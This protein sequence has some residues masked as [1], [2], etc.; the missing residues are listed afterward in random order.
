MKKLRLMLL[1]K[2]RVSTL[3]VLGFSTHLF[4]QSFTLLTDERWLVAQLPGHPIGY[5]TPPTSYADFHGYLNSFNSANDYYLASVD[6]TLSAEQLSFNSSLNLQGA[7]PPNG[8]A[9]SFGAYCAVNF[10]VSSPV[11]ATFAFNNFSVSEQGFTYDGL[12]PTIGITSDD[13]GFNPTAAA[14]DSPYNYTIDAFDNT[15]N[16][17][18]ELAFSPNHTYT[19]FEQMTGFGMRGGDTTYL[20]ATLQANMS[21]TTM[22]GQ[23][24]VFVPEPSSGFLLFLGAGFVTLWWRYSLPVRSPIRTRVRR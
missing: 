9:A 12:I 4:A 17:S 8:P 16:G 18:V 10:S 11:T 21:L 15:A 19:F 1:S 22:S 7:I 2:T 23:M 14:G 5:Q 3:L 13:P 20:A 6:S 24:P